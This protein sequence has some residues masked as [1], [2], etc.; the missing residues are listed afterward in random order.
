MKLERNES[1]CCGS[2]KKY[3]KCCLH[4]HLKEKTLSSKNH[5]E[6]PHFTIELRP[7][8]EQA[9]DDA[10]AILEKGDLTSAKKLAAPLI[11]QYP[12]NHHVLFLQGVCFIQEQHH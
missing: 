6:V 11:L 5:Q 8:V 10:L 7:E 1:C 9:C 12:N 2:G 3:K 4:I